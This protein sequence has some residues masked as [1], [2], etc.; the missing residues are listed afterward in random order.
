MTAP[1]SPPAA[2]LHLKVFHAYDL[3]AG[4]GGVSTG[5]EAATG[6]PVTVAINH[7]PGAI[8]VHEANHPHTHHLISDV[9]APSPR[10]VVGRKRPYLLWASPDCTHFSRAKGGKP[11]NAK[12]RALAWVVVD[13]AREVRPPVICV[14]NV[15]EFVTWGPLDEKGYPIAER[16]GETFAQWRGALELLGYKIE[17]RS[18]VA[19]HYGAPTSRKRFFLVA[20]CD[21]LPIRWPEPTHGP[22]LL[23]FHTAAECIDW[24]IPSRSIF[25]RSRP[26]KPNTLRRIAAGIDR[27]VFRAAD[28][29]VVPHGDGFD[30]PLIQ[31]GYGERKG[32]RP[33]VLDLHAPLGTVVNGQKHA[34]VTAFLAR[35]YTGMIGSDVRSPLPTITATDHHGLVSASLG[36]VDRR[37]QVRAFLAAY[38][39]S[40]G[41][42]AG[43]SLREPLRT[44]VTRDRFALVTVA[45]V[46]HEIYDIGHRMLHWRELLRAQFGR[47]AQAY[48]LSAVKTVKE[49]I[50]LIGNSVPPEMAEALVRANISHG[51]DRRS[52]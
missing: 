19:C 28:P 30:A 22:G 36:G 47:F 41:K 39:G 43:Q 45:G 6:H 50:K 27:F 24:A 23:P 5:I 38:Y 9:W 17:H 8:A 11:R 26:L 10:A 18:L 49:K 37:V 34:L 29:F 42:D 20:R 44:V 51:L 12:I 21:G 3:F 25:D 7:S 31:S 15:E 16:E 33:R 32:Q 46:E 2:D 40:D 14:E 52:A 48:D 4:G 35:H 13:W 1:L